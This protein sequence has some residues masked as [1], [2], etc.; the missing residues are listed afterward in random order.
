MAQQAMHGACEHMY[1]KVHSMPNFRL[2]FI[3]RGHF[4]PI[5]DPAW[6]LQHALKQVLNALTFHK[7]IYACVIAR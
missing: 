3:K 7:Q 5:L 4:F 6:Y 1:G 2:S